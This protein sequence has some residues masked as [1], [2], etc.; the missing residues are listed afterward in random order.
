MNYDI[1]KDSLDGLFAYDMGATDSGIHDESLR[2]RVKTYLATLPEAD[3][4]VL[5]DRIV[6]DFGWESED[7]REFVKWLDRHMNFKVPQEQEEDS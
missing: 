1:L 2:E 4:T 6:G 5:V 7:R 3:K